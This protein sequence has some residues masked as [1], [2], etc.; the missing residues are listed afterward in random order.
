MNK[1]QAEKRIKELIKLDKYLNSKEKE[2][3]S[4]WL[5]QKEIDR[6]LQESKKKLLEESKKQKED[7]EQQLAERLY[8][9]VKDFDFYN[10]VDNTEMYRSEEDNINI[11]KADINDTN[12][13]KDYIK[14]LKEIIDDSRLSNEDLKE[15]QELVY[16]LEQRVPKYKYHLGDTIYIGSD[17]YEFAGI[18]NGI[19]K[20]YD[21]KFPLFNKEMPFEE[22][23]RKVQEN[24][25]N[26]HLIVKDKQ[27]QHIETAKQNNEEKYQDDVVEQEQEKHEETKQIENNIEKLDIKIKKQVK[28]K[29]TKIQDYVLHPEIPINERNNFKINNENLGVG[30]PR[31]KFAKNVA[32][33]QVLKKCENENRYATLEE[34][35]ILSNYVGWGGLQQAFDEKDSSWTNEYR[36]LKE[37]L[38]EDEYKSARESTLTAFYTPPVV[39]NSIYEVLQNMG[40]KEANV[41]EPACGTGNFLGLLPK[42]L[43]NCKIYGVEK[44]SISGRIAQQLYQKSTIA[45][46]GYEKVDMPDSFFDVAIG[47]V[48]FGDISINDRKYNKNHFLIHDYF[49]A[50]TIDKVRPRR[51]CCF[52]YI[53]RNNG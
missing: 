37:L 13:V 15:V 49:F 2:E 42:E 33:I 29:R 22:F 48:P 31:E 5:K 6:E 40:L 53:K 20:L 9:F 17:E 10:Y 34:Q 26:E 4:N 36:I 14:E 45:I 47:N 39:I 12:N 21:V 41:L 25:A 24:Y 46:S 50:K 27:I 28:P 7:A 18:N 23:E 8:K 44:D 51:N 1:E 35:E 19:V 11:I 30:T 3:Y 32:A 43:L 16:I 52:C 38:T